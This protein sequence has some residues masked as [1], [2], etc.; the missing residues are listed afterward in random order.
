[1][2]TAGLG[3]FSSQLAVWPWETLYIHFCCTC[4]YWVLTE[5]AGWIYCAFRADSACMWQFPRSV[6]VT[7]GKWSVWPAAICVPGPVWWTAVRAGNCGCHGLT[8]SSCCY[9]C[10]NS[11]E[12]LG[13]PGRWHRRKRSASQRP[14]TPGGGHKKCG[15]WVRSVG[16][17]IQWGR[18]ESPM[19]EEGE[20]NVGGESL[21]SGHSPWSNI[22]IK[23]PNFLRNPY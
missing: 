13:S 19:G 9:S 23:L 14:P 18:R 1:V 21:F 15:H 7:L 20:S 17:R 6:P 22:N 16:R 2:E 10:C 5:A 8:C 12:R 3:Q 4:R 11:P